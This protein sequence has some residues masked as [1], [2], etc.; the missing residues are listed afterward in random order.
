VGALSRARGAGQAFVQMTRAATS[1]GKGASSTSIDQSQPEAMS[2]VVAGVTAPRRFQMPPLAF[3]ILYSVTYEPSTATVAHRSIL[4]GSYAPTTT[5][6]HLHIR[7]S[8]RIMPRT[9]RRHFAPRV[10]GVSHCSVKQ[11]KLR[12][13]LHQ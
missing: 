7:P 1:I 4:S 5:P 2:R 6:H 12:Q 3:S 13:A 9:S 8:Q 11:T 10:H